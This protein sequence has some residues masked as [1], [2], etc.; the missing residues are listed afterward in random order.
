MQ[1]KGSTRAKRAAPRV[2]LD[3]RPLQGPSGQRGIG[4]YAR[5]LIGG[6][7]SEG[8]ESNLTLLLDVDLPEPELPKGTYAL[9]GARRRYKGQLSAYEEAVA[10]SAD[11]KR[12]GRDVYHAVDLRLPGVPPYPMVVTLHDLIPWAWKDRSMRGEQLRF[13]LGRRLLKRAATVIAV[14]QSTADD[15]VRLAGIAQSRIHVVAEAA[16]AAFKPKEGAAERVRSRWGLDRG[17]LIHVGAL[18]VRKDPSS[19]MAAWETARGLVPGLGLVLAGSPGKQAP[20]E[21]QGAR[22]LGHVTVDELADLYSVAGCLVFPSR[23]EG[24]GLTP[25]EAMSCGCPVVAYHNSS[26][27]EVVG[28][29][30]ALVDDGDAQA[31]G[32]AAAAQVRDPQAAR[33]A[34]L[35]RAAAFSWRR[36]ARL[37][38][39]TYEALL[40]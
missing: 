30:G 23:Y 33:S 22:L 35:K 3:A 39:A 2:L 28:D 36:T 25:L 12:I 14:S 15:A 6:L 38:I 10:L 26:I 7:V 11:L 37:V 8:F 18:D 16:D 13:W 21:L 32:R 24:F 29:A 34:G 1:E 9:A 4:S 20:R 19:L 17:F 31:L 5:G 27:P 40:R